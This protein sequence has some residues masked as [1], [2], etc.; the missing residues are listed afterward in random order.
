MTVDVTETPHRIRLLVTDA[1]GEPVHFEEYDLKEG[2]VVPFVPQL[3]EHWTLVIHE[4]TMKCK[5]TGRG[6]E[7]VFNGESIHTSLNI[8]AQKLE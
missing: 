2:I 8:A 3:E 1:E 4:T 5:V 7:T 6:V